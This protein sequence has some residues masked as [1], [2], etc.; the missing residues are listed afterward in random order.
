MDNFKEDL[1]YLA[2]L[3]GWKSY[4]VAEVN[5]TKNKS[6]DISDEILEQIKELNQKDMDLYERALSIKNRRN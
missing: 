6:K 4:S 1:D 5:K 3:L 2:R